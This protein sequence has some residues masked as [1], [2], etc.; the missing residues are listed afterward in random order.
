LAEM[1]DA[2]HGKGDSRLRLE[3]ALKV[4]EDQKNQLKI[5]EKK[6]YLD[7]EE[8]LKDMLKQIAHKGPDLRKA[9]I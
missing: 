8:V 5:E 2:G 7:R 3:Q 4:L 6:G 9:G 1:D